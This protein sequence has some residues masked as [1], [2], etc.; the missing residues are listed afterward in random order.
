MPDVGSDTKWH[1]DLNWHQENG[2]S[3]SALAEVYLCPDCLKTVKMETE[4]EKVIETI[5]LC[6][7]NKPGFFKASTPVLATV[8]QIFLRNANKPLSLEELSKEVALRRP[9]VPPLPPERL[10]RIL[11]SDNYYGLRP[12]QY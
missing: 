9:Q 1:L 6:C 7:G 2:C 5:S 4:A 10:E 11:M 8:F 12:A 3:F